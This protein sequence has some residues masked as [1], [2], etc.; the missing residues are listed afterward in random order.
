MK[1][2]YKRLFASLALVAATGAFV[3]SPV[4][5]PVAQAKSTHSSTHKTSAHKSATKPKATTA[6][7]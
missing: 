7:S 5:A 2:Q 6:P 1:T 4:L 3:A